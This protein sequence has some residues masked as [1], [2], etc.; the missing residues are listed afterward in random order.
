MALLSSEISVRN[1]VF[2]GQ[3]FQSRQDVA[4]EIAQEKP[5]RI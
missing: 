5:F 3:E 1:P 4:F 2:S